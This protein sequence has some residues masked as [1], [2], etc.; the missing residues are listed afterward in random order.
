MRREIVAVAVLVLAVV[1]CTPPGPGPQPTPTPNP[2]ATAT[3]SPSPTPSASATSAPPTS[4]P[5]TTVSPP[6]GWP[7]PETTGVPAGTVLRDWTGSDVLPPGEYVAYRFP[8]RVSV[9]SGGVV[10]RNSHLVQ[11]INNFTE[12]GGRGFRI[13]DSTLGTATGCY[14]DFVLGVTDFVAVRVEVY[15]DDGVRISERGWAPG[16]PQITVEDSYIRPCNSSSASHSDGLQAYGTDGPATVK[17]NTF[18]MRNAPIYTAGL[19]WQ[20]DYRGATI[21]DNLFIGQGPADYYGTILSGSVGPLHVFDGNR[22]ADYDQPNRGDQCDNVS[23]GAD[24]RRVT[25]GTNYQI[26]S[27]GA[28]VACG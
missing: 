2:S 12:G 21:V 16:Q 10:I 28:E 8:R 15:G 4:A 26:A 20:S 5:P 27:V 23:W 6:D 18:D 1:G 22:Y 24:N 11:G 7:S 25:L 17:H 14:P 3:P 13:E 19:F 9:A